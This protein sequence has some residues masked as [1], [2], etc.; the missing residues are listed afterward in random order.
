[1]SGGNNRIVGN[2]FHPRDDELVGIYLREKLNGRNSLS[3]IITLPEVNNLY[4]MEP[5]ELPLLPWPLEFDRNDQI[6]YFYH[7]FDPG[8]KQQKRV[9]KEGFWS[10]T[11][12]PK[13]IKD[14]K[15]RKEIGFKR[16]MTYYYK[17]CG[18]VRKR[19]E[20]KTAWVMHEIHLTANPPNQN[21]IVL[22]TL[23]YK[24]Y[25][26]A[27]I[28]TN[29]G[30]LGL[31]DCSETCTPKGGS[32]EDGIGVDDYEISS[33]DFG[34]FANDERSNLQI[35]IVDNGGSNLTSSGMNTPDLANSSRKRLRY[36]ESGLSIDTGMEGVLAQ[37]PI[38]LCKS[39]TNEEH[40]TA[41]ISSN[42][43]QRSL[44]VPYNSENSILQSGSPDIQDWIETDELLAAFNQVDD[45]NWSQLDFDLFDFDQGSNQQNM[46]VEN[47]ASNSPS[48]D[49][50]SFNFTQSPTKRCRFDAETEAI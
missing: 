23:K 50:I 3:N 43:A 36:E 14:R 25:E 35:V 10:I 27:D 44:S 45:T 42:E 4:E 24:E 19:K 37:N 26:T 11:G 46:V 18:Y 13:K 21:T 29:E 15:S 49:E 1:M 33:V 22:Y 38:V 40:K 17:D 47:G 12:N 39:S 9:T 34:G 6:W 30:Q 41:D 20:N 7:R 8:K 5:K 48:F 28:S 16:T 32:S 31:A 2:R